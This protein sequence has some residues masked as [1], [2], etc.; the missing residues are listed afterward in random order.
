MDFQSRHPVTKFILVF[1]GI[2]ISFWP[3]LP[4]WLSKLHIDISLNCRLRDIRDRTRPLKLIYSN[5][6]TN[7]IG[8]LIFL[9][10]NFDSWQ[11]HRFWN[12]VNQYFFSAFFN[13][14]WGIL[15][16]PY[17]FL[18]WLGGNPYFFDWSF[19]HDLKV[20]F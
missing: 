12:R 6:A 13:N 8:L 7:F 18:F 5:L 9:F 1:K 3:D 11:D 15:G 14:N 17:F 16:R 20:R 2:E 4:D 19:D 10:Q